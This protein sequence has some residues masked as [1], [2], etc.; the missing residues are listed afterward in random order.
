MEENKHQNTTALDESTIG[1]FAHIL[2]L[3][4]IFG[5]LIIYLIYKDK[6]S[7]NLKENMVNSLNWQISTIIYSI[8]CFILIIVLIG[9]L[10][11]MVLGLCNLIFCILGAIEASNNKVYRYPLALNFIKA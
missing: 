9:L 4:T 5:P 1:V 2:G 10:G 3:F 6:A 8:I 11:L 7:Q